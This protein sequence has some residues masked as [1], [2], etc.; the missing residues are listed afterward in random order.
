VSKR[1]ILVAAIGAVVAGVAAG[2][3]VEPARATQPG[4]VGSLAFGMR[5]SSGTAKKRCRIVVRKVHH[6]RKRVRICRR[7]KKVVPPAATVVAQASLGTSNSDV[8][9][10][11]AVGD[12]SIWATLADGQRIV[13]IDPA[14]LRV[15][16]TI[17]NPLPVEWAP[18]VAYG[19]G[20]VWLS[21]AIPGVGSGSPTGALVRIDPATNAVVATVPVGRSPEGLAFTAGA[22]WSANHRSDQPQ[23]AAPPHTFSVSR[24]DVASNTATANVVVETRADT[25]DSWLNFCCGP[26]GAAAGAG[27]VW[28]ADTTT[29]QVSRIDPATNTVTARIANPGHQACGSMAANDTSVWLTEG[30][31]SEG[32]WRIDPAS[33]RVAAT[34]Q[35]PGAGGDVR[36]AFGSVWVSTSLIGGFAAA[37]ETLTRIDPLTN[38]VVGRTPIPSA[39]PLAV[40]DGVLWMGSGSS[41]RELRPAA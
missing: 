36:L 16:A 2:A 38:R 29:N 21:E 35:L 4:D 20:A 1:I 30:C 15:T 5:D 31:N 17:A 7:V 28:V 10:S 39:G 25:G 27:S 14:T 26:Q 8:I 41:L 6:H 37:K 3:L 40:G 32:L 11:L 18:T 13:R 34:L 9:A 22:V 19:D 33:N 23:D 24:V 12:G